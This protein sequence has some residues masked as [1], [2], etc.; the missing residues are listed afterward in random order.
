MIFRAP[1]PDVTIP[2][3]PITAFVLQNAK[4]LGS[5][6][7]LIDGP[8]GRVITYADLAESVSRAATGLHARGFKKGDVFAI[9]SPNVPEYAIAFHGV[10]SLGGITCTV[11]PLYTEQ[12]IAHQLKDS[13]ARF[14]VTIP[15]CLRKANSAAAL[16]TNIEEVFVFVDDGSDDDAGGANRAGVEQPGL[17]EAHGR[18]PLCE[19]ADAV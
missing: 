13:G 3:V 10:A 5:K 16:G 11:N 15:Q 2:E 12:E 14:L 17:Y 6:P 8:T 18:R 9:L 19:L 1:F 7:A 4:G